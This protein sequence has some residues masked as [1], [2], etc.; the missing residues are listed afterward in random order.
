MHGA[1]PAFHGDPQFGVGRG[2]F[3]DGQRGTHAVRGAEENHPGGAQAAGLADT[4]VSGLDL[5]DTGLA[6]RGV[7][8]FHVTGRAVEHGRGV[9]QFRQ[10]QA[11]G[12][13]PDFAD[14]PFAKATVAAHQCLVGEVLG[15]E[16]Q[17]NQQ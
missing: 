2:L 3:R 1:V 6:Q 14:L 11:P 5:A 10:A 8:T 7:E 12:T 9:A 13:D 4:Q 15:H 17:G 16:T